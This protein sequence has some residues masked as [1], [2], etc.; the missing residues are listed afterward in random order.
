MSQDNK[1][2]CPLCNQDFTPADGMTV[3]E[4]LARG[5]L[6]T[7]AAMQGKSD[8]YDNALPCPRCGE[9]NMAGNVLQNALSRQFDVYICDA[10]GNKEGV[11]AYEGT[12]LA[13]E[14]W[15]VVAEILKRNKL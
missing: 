11:E 10:C 6:R 12:P 3:G 13:L 4:H 9:S 5:V 2:T 15:W 7:Y 14:A 8:D 1:C